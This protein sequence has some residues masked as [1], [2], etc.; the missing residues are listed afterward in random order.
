MKT[1]TVH[2][3]SHGL[4]DLHFTMHPC[5]LHVLEP[6]RKGSMFILTVEENTK[7]FNKQQIVGATVAR[8]TYKALGHGAI[9]GCKLTTED[10][11]ISFKIFGPS[12]IKDKGN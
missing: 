6:P 8:K 4:V 2:Q 12:I 5:G 3:E 7:F 1:F 11:D 9:R 10:A